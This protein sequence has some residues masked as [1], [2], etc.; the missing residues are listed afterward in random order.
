MEDAAGSVLLAGI[1]KPAITSQEKEFFQNAGIAGLTLFRRNIP[2]LFQDLKSLNESLQNQRPSGAPPLLIAVDQEGGR[3]RRLPDPFPDPGPPLHFNIPTPEWLHN[4]GFVCGAVLQGLGINV[5]FAPVVDVLANTENE[6]IGDRVFAREAGI[7]A[8]RAGAWLRGLQAGGVLGC[9]KH[10]P[11]QGD[12][13]ADTHGGP[14]TIDLSREKLEKRELLPFRLLLD[15]APMVMI[16]HGIY[17]ALDPQPASLSSVVMQDLLRGH[18]G[19]TG[20][21]VSD[22]MNM[23]AIPQDDRQWL[24]ALEAGLMA[25]ADL[26]LICRHMERCRLAWEHFQTRAGRSKA[27]K[28]RLEE[29]AGR[30]LSLRK[31]IGPP[32]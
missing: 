14:A 11:G 1:E 23:G 29:A 9:L 3:V 17:P 32:N 18:L 28:K 19:F 2:P 26:L 24:D 20:V 13:R 21:V 22:D 6:A 5:N 8:D 30:V 16:G 10:F 25:G 12:A 31:K 27:V 15:R 4:Q 7:V